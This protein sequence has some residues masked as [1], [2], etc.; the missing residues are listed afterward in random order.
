MDD[1]KRSLLVLL[2]RFD[3]GMLCTRQPDGTMRA[4]PMAVA[5]IEQNGDLWFVT[6]IASGKVEEVLHEPHVVVTM[7]GRRRFVSVSGHAEV[8]GDEEKIAEL[9]REEWRAWFPE[10]L[11]D[12]RLVL[13]HVRASEAEYWDETGTRGAKHA[14]E[15]ARAALSGKRAPGHEVQ[16]HGHVML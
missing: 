8:V 14:L 2:D 7:Q 16:E 10:G 1:T 15:S 3:T 5:Q 13:L 9:W 6:G 11:N 12:P 4:R